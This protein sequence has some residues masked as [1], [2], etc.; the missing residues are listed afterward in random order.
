MSSAVVFAILFTILLNIQM[1]EGSDSGS[2]GAAGAIIGTIWIIL[3][4]LLAYAAVGAKNMAL[5]AGLISLA[6]LCLSYPALVKD[7]QQQIGKISLAATVALIATSWYLADLQTVKLLT[8]L[9]VWLSI[10]NFFLQPNR[11]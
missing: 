3:I 9:F 6:A 10:A 1:L 7:R 11:K 5:K 8:P 2:S 4:G